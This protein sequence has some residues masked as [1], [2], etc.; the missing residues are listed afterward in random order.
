MADNT[1]TGRQLFFDLIAASAEPRPRSSF[2]AAAWAVAAEH[3][4]SRVASTPAERPSCD[5]EPVDLADE[6]ELLDPLTEPAHPEGAEAAAG[7]VAFG[8]STT[9]M[10]LRCTP[11][12][13]RPQPL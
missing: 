13:I 9:A 10:N 5:L 12:R 11:S 6:A 7:P 4:S 3:A 1:T 2:E 8:S